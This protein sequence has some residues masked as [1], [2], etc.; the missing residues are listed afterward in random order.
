MCV[1][2]WNLQTNEERLGKRKGIVTC[3]LLAETYKE[4]SQRNGDRDRSPIP[5]L[6]R[7]EL[8]LYVH[9]CSNRVETGGHSTHQL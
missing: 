3:V 9:V 5:L 8:L 7:E 1:V 2:G 4:T 6:K